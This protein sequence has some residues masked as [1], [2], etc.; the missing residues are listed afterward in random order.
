MSQVTAEELVLIETYLHRR[1]E[2]DPMVRVATA[3]QIAGRVK[4]KTG[5]V[6]QP[7]QSVDDFL[8]TAARL[9]RDGARFR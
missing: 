2:L 8:E 7:G 9:I 4:T 5:L 6:E 3:V 1:W